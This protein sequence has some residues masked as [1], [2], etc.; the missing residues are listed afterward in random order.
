MGLMSTVRGWFSSDRRTFAAD[1]K[2][3][4]ALVQGLF[5]GQPVQSVSRDQALSVPAFLR[6]RN[7]ICSISTL[8]LQTIDDS[9]RIIRGGMLDQINP[10]VANTVTKAQ[11]VEDLLF[12]SVAWWRV[13][14]FDDYGYPLTCR[15][16]APEKVSINLPPGRAGYNPSVLP[17]GLPI[18]GLIWMDGHP[19]PY[20]E[21]IRFDSPNPPVLGVAGSVVLDRAIALDAAAA[22][23]ASDPRPMDYFTPSDATAD[24][25]DDAGILTLLKN[26]ATSRKQRS[27]AYVPAA[28][29]YNEVQSPTPADLQLVE[30]QKK[31]TLDIANLLGIDPEDV[32]V[33]TT[34]RTYQNGVD[35]RQDRVNDT[36]ASYMTAIT[37]RLSMPDV[38]PPGQTVRFYLDDFLKADPKSRAE[39]Q[40]IYLAGGVISA[41]EVRDQEGLTPGAPAPRPI[42]ATVGA[43]VSQHAIAAAA[44][45]YTF[46]RQ[47]LAFDAEVTTFS[48]DEARRTI[49]GLAVPFGQTASSGGRR[50]RFAPGAIKWAAVNRVKLLRDHNQS[51]AL[52]KATKITETA[53]GIE[54]T[55]SVSAGRAGDE[56][57]ALAA[58]GVL[59]GL[60]IGVDFRDADFLPD[61]EN[62]GAFLVS[63]AALRE[64]SLTAVPAFDD[65]RLTSVRASDE[66]TSTVPC[67]K[68][69]LVHADGVIECQTTPA[70]VPESPVTFAQMQSMMATFAAGQTPPATPAAVVPARP[71]VDPTNS[72]AV[73]VSEASAYRF[74]RSGFNFLPTEHTFSSDLLAMAR[75]GDTGE[76]GIKTDAGRRVFD[77]IRRQFVNTATTNVA[78]LNPTLQRPDMY[79]DQRD[80]RYPL[81]EALSKGAPPNGVQPFIFPK[82]SSNGTL[83][84]PHTEGTEPTAGNYV[85]TNQTVQPTALSGKASLTREVWDMGGNPAVSSLVWGQMTRSWNEGF[86]VAIG[87]FLNTLTAA[88]DI[89]LNTGATATQPPTSAQLQANWESAIAALQFIR[90]YDWSLLAMEPFAYQAFIAARDTTGQPMYPILNPMNRNGTAAERFRTLNLNGIEGVPAWGLGA[91]TA[92]SP[93]NSWLVDPSVVWAWRTAPERLEF[94]GTNS[95]GG[96]APVAMVDIGIWGYNAFANSDIGGVRQVT[97]D[98]TT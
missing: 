73:V 90:G 57:L 98:T 67:Q 41:E 51:L 42:P 83:V 60:S 52:G 68:C 63:S 75:A 95:A 84:G 58:D 50:W 37:D 65:S 27:T 54:V 17:S 71:T 49:T 47:G 89:T 30:L 77:L 66:R 6:G 15:R 12:H 97:Y 69:G 86:E 76:G 46:A 10:N 44:D 79:V 28:L 81:T 1:Y 25:V 29:T 72:G 31:V 82:F 11:T 85:T 32:G 94:P 64:V 48:V 70:A 35:R 53:A 80:F 21:V 19:V 43:P 14:S 22:M 88:T 40:Q 45:V 55:F 39:V 34:S 93:N 61:P 16:Y 23:Y 78:S 20:S 96:Y 7:L 24:P 4:N 5:P 56:A 36:L 2:P 18:E 13:T 33:S 9:N 74:D 38:T 59:D 87:T 62:P 3:V 91:G 8:P 92:G 26:W